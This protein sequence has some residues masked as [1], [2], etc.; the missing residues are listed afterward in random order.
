MHHLIALMKHA[1]FFRRGG[2]WGKKVRA[3]VAK[4]C[5]IERKQGPIERKTYLTYAPFL[6]G[7]VHKAEKQKA[8]RGTQGFGRKRKKE[9]P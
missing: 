9:P 4:W 8:L 1:K 5:P 7:I 6:Q 2:C 3:L